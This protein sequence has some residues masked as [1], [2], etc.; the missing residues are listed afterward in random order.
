MK[1]ISDHLHLALPALFVTILSFVTLFTYWP[2][3]LNYPFFIARGMLP[4]RDFS[5]VYVPLLPLFLAGV[6]QIFGFQP[7][8]LHLVA[9]LFLV[10]IVLLLTL[11]VARTTRSR[12]LAVLAGCLFAFIL[13]AFEGNHFWFDSVLAPLFFLVFLFQYSYLQKPHPGKIFLSGIVTALAL[14]AKQTTFYIFPAILCFFLFL[15]VKRAYSLLRL[16]QL[17]VIFLAPSAILVSLFLLA[18]LKLDL[19][20]DFLH[21]GVRFVSVLT[22]MHGENLGPDLYI[23][24]LRQLL[25]FLPL[26]VLAAFFALKSKR[27]GIKLAFLWMLFSAFLIYP[28]FGYFHL[29]PALVFF[30]VVVFLSMQDLP[31]RALS[32]TVAIVSAIIL[33]EATPV[34]IRHLRSG[35]AFWDS[36]TV[37]IAAWIGT[38][39]PQSTVY[40][41]NGPDLVYVLAN[42][43]PSA[44]PWVDQLSWNMAFFGDQNYLSAFSAHP[45]DLVVFKPYQKGEYQPKGVINYFFSHYQKTRSFKNG[46]EIWVRT[47]KPSV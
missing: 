26:A 24:T 27:F 5:M 7:P 4:Y 35:Q 36:Q 30:F 47:T 44:L 28:R 14:L 8:V 9:T 40:S 6:Y 31:K 1:R 16:G 17:V 41:L 12:T 46:I 3:M 10:G 38:N 20:S 11:F 39:Y 18:L 33:V 25:T 13:I 23:P 37:E 19:L 45:P 43:T 42:K 21:W 15:R 29:E 34:L 22:S 2:E 32:K